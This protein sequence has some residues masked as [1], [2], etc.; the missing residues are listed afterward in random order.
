MQGIKDEDAEIVLLLNTLFER[1]GYDFRQY[2]RAHIKRR[3]IG[4]MRVSG[5]PDI[6]SLRHEVYHDLQRA[7]ALLEGLSITVTEMFRDPDFYRMVRERVVPMLRTWSHIKIWH[8]G[9]ATGEEVYSMAILLKEEGLYDR[10]QIYATDLNQRALEQA[11]EGIYPLEVMKGHARNYQRSGATGS[12]TDHCLARYGSAIMD[13]SLKRNIL[14]SSHNLVT[15]SDFAEVQ[16]VVCRNV[17]IYF[18]RTLQQRVHGLFHRSLVNGG[19]LCLGAKETIDHSGYEA[20][21]EAVD[22]RQRIFRKKYPG[23]R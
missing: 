21:Y 20:S 5:H 11:A 22:R 17:M 18:D 14:W 2:S 13:G 4:H 23:Q 3:I 8:A 6:A 16:M 15:D 19:V 12:F 1:Y 7:G 10:T 9:C